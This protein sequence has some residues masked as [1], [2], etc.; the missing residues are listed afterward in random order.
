ML[1]AR[2]WLAGLLSALLL[3]AC[4]TANRQAAPDRNAL[5]SPSPSATAVVNDSP[6][7]VSHVAD[8][9]GVW[10]LN[11]DL[12]DNAE[13]KLKA[14]LAS[15]RQATGAKGPSGDHGGR[16]EGNKRRGLGGGGPSANMAFS[17]TGLDALKFPSQRLQ[18]THQDPMLLIIDDKGHKKRLFTDNR[19]SSISASGGMNQ[20]VSTAGW[21]QHVLVVETTADNGQRLLQRYALTAAGAQLSIVATLHL[22]RQLQPIVITRIYQRDP[23][24]RDNAL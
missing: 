19:G 20:Q 16:G 14:A 2:R 7:P 21:E 8:L 4:S 11:T 1:N 24:H 13:E 22:P 15:H 17:A 9:S 6:P 12:S 5:A 3:S 23:S 18:I 10:L